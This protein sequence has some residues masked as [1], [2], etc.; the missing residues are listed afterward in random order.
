MT[1]VFAGSPLDRVSHRRRDRRW[2]EERMSA[3]ESRYL[4]LWRLQVLLRVGDPPGIAWAT[5][6]IRK[7]GD[8]RTGAVFLGVAS[9]V[10]HFAVDLSELE[11]PEHELG[12][13]GS[14][15]F[16]DVRAAAAQLSGEE[17]AIVAQARSLIDWHQ[18][19]RFCPRCGEPTV[20]ADGGNARVCEDCDLEHFPRT[21][22]VAIMLVSRG[23][24]CLLG[25]Q[26]GWPAGMWSALAG[27]I[28]PGETIEEAVRREV[29]EE[30]AIEVGRVRYHASQPWPFPSSLMIGCRA[31]ATSEGIVVDRSEL[32]DARWFAREQVLAGLEAGGG[33]A[34]F[35]V[36]PPMAIAHQLIRAWA[37]RDSG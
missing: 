12:L 27:F 16:S 11:K 26:A 14:A 5:A 29:R 24:R 2:L 10:A 30:S 1:I 15:V 23:D 25:R 28:E 21:N 31:E 19:H 3:P 18:S 8:A 17:A 6:E 33:S 35:F 13:A 32:E 34:G 4:A 7:L 9:D 20:L 36:P 37:L 22:P